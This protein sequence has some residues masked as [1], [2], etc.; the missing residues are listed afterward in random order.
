M[1]AS[2]PSPSTLPARRPP[3]L[4]WVGT[5]LAIGL[6]VYLLSREGWQEIRVALTHIEWW[7]FALAL[8]L[9]MLSRLAVAARW[10][11][12]MHSAATGITFRQSVAIT[13]AGL[14][15]SN[16]LPTTIG[17][18][19]V[20]LAGAMRLGFDKTVSLASLVVDR[21]V[22]M[23]GMALALPFALPAFLD[24]G[25]AQS[26][27]DKP[28]LFLS[29]PWLDRLKIGTARLFKRLVDALAIWL[30]QPRSLL[31]ALACTVVHMLCTFAQVWLLLAGMGEHVSFWLIAGLWS[32]TYFVTLLPISI[33]GLGVQ[34]LSMAFF[35]TTF[36]G[37]S[38]SNALT[39]ALLMRLLQMLAS[40]PGALTIPGLLEGRRAIIDEQVK[41]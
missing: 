39:L 9:V 23:A 7:R 20:R 34:E 2:L 32:A 5:L 14:F 38:Q 26:V 28:F 33:N 13:F 24:L 17:G 22:G 41:Q 12:L 19:V 8:L 37:I 35:Y 40:L 30:H 21:L 18:D 3:L 31:A 36:A 10:H 25:Y 1:S 6:L 16:F 4:R 27:G 15:A 29:A 11:V